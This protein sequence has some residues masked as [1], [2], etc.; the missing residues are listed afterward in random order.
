MAPAIPVLLA[1]FL[2]LQTVLGQSTA[3]QNH[4]SLG[5]SLARQGKLA[6]AEEELRQAVQLDPEVPA[7]RAQLGSILGLR[8]KWDD[9]L[10]HFQ[11]AVELD[12]EN[13]DFRRETAAVQ[14]QVGL[15]PEAVKN[16]QYVLSRRPDDSG[17]IL[18]LGL[19]EEKTGDYRRAAQLL[20]SQLDLVK[21]QP[22]R[23]VALFDSLVQSGQRNK[24]P[25]IVELLKQRANDHLWA[26]AIGR[27]TE[28]SLSDGDLETARTLFGLIPDSDPVR[29]AV[30]VQI[31]RLL[32]ERGQV[33]S[34]KDLLLAF[35]ENGVVSSDLQTLLGNCLE[36]EH[37]PAGALEAYR[38]AIEINPKRVDSYHDPISLLLDVGKTDEALVLANRAMAM[39]PKD[40]KPWLWKGNVDLRKHSYKD[41][42]ESFARA[43][44]LDPSSADPILGKAAVYFISGQNDAAIAEF[45]AG[46]VRFPTDARL[47]VMY[48]SML[49]SSSDSA[50]RLSEAQDLLQKAVKLDPLSAE[51]HYQLGQMALQQSHLQDAEEEF[52]LSLRSDASRSKTHFALSVVYRRTGRND[53]AAKEFALFEQLKATEQANPNA[54]LTS[55]GR[56]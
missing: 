44:Q 14:W 9:A 43:S 16:L 3:A 10:R 13:L 32:Y 37:N 30:G 52:L 50:Q 47:Y 42:M 51:A 1:A 18:L 35:V 55:T 48:A 39:A 20:E 27:C 22:D 11:R 15:M 25:P 26:S 24:L 41:A 49:L 33:S 17:S 31:A 19:V 56:P 5:I 29:P 46:I 38:R 4:A 12:P 7:Y 8:E 2:L 54:A 21:A 40:A 6:E 34:A 28:I 23:T 53:E 45:K 36:A